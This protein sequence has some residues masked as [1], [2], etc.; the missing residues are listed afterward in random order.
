MAT[1]FSFDRYVVDLMHNY[2]AYC[3]RRTNRQPIAL[4]ACSRYPSFNFAITS[5][6]IHHRF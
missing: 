4:T 3:Q 5:V 6:N 1:A 2:V